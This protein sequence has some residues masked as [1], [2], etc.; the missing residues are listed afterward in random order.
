MKNIFRFLSVV[1]FAT[2][3]SCSLEPVSNASSASG[4]RV[5]ELALGSGPSSDVMLQGFHWESHLSSSWWNVVSGN[6]G[7]IGNAGFTMVW[8]PPSQ[9]A[10][11]DEGYLPRRLYV[12]DSSYGT[13]VELKSAIAALHGQGVKVIADIVIN[14]R[15]GTTDWADFTDPAWGSD[16]VCGDDEWTGATGSSDTGSGYAAARDIDHT[17]AYVQSSIIDWMNWL[18]SNIGYDGWRYDYVKGYSGYYNQVYNNATSPYFSVGELWPDITGDYYASGSGVNY[19]RQL[20][21]DWITATGST[22]AAFDFTTKWQLMLAVDRNEYWRLKDADGKPIGLI[23]WWPSHA[24]TFI[25]NHDTGPSTGGT[26]GQNH[27]SF[28]SGAVMQGYAYILTHP[29]VPSV[30]WP[31]YFDWGLGSE[32]DKL[33]AIRKAAGITSE[34]SV[35]IQVADSSKY[36]A[37]VNGNVAVKIGAGNWDPG[38]GWALAASGQDYAVWTLDNSSS[39]SSSSSSQGSGVRTVIFMHK[40]T[41]S[42]QDIFV[43]GGH[44]GGLVD[45]GYYPTMEEPI[46]YNN[47]LNATTADIKAADDSLDWFTE[48]ALDW[49]T[50]VWPADWGTKRTYAADGYGED[51]ENQWGQH[52][53]KFDVQMQGNVGDWY[54][55]KAFMREGSNEY[56]ES[57]ISQSGT[58]QQSINHWGRKGYITRVGFGESWAEFIPLY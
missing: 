54:E 7:T 11:S 13:E 44:D 14:H 33:I 16:A 53:W 42:G 34:S 9:D 3:V 50:D 49:T 23:G 31:H 20:L 29:G 48:S 57:D 45:Q 40:Q 18:K 28:P 8:M 12:Q 10:A 4:T 26:G 58:P 37:I 1:L 32:I 38:T 27:W 35:S 21:C 41:V 17:K 5:Q 22:S 52:W 36:A 30:Y 25:D 19:H 39:S 56:W 2:M 24:V 55:F 46:T 51:P 43:K 6:A 15:V 47:T